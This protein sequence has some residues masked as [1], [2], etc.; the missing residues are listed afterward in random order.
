MRSADCPFLHP[1]G[2]MLII[3]TSVMS[4]FGSQAF[5]VGTNDSGPYRLGEGAILRKPR[6]RSVKAQG[7]PTADS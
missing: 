7:S 2:L 3:R 5:Y 4:P 6:P 1:S